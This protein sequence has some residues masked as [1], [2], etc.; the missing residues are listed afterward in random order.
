M[1]IVGIIGLLYILTLNTLALDAGLLSSAQEI[2][3]KHKIEKSLT[4]EQKFNAYIVLAFEL[5]T[6]G[7]LKE[8]IT[9]YEKAKALKP[10]KID[11]LE[12]ETSYLFALFK[13]DQ[14][15]AK[16]YFKTYKKEIVNS[17]DKNKAK[18]L[19]YWEAVFSNSK[20]IQNGFY[21]Q[22]F[23]DQNLKELMA[24]KDYAKALALRN[25]T[26][27]EHASINAK[28]EYDVLSRLRGKKNGFYCE[29]MLKE[30]PNSY[31]VSMEI[32][33]YIKT[34]KLKH[35]G[36]KELIQRAKKEAPSLHYLTLALKD[37]ES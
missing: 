20:K 13:S 36:L 11:P 4:N 3:K 7:H 8:A 33:R 28:I 14:K 24:K 18:I 31:A 19:D 9:F 10:K 25:P 17:K 30:F 5:E 34:G 32:C 2:V 21:G 1:K 26:G 23:K 22:F 27:L 37:I 29:Q 6:H 35:K 12:L 16:S 15:K